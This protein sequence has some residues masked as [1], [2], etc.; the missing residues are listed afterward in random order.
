MLKDSLFDLFDFDLNER[1]WLLLSLAFW[2]D[3][4]CFFFLF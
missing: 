4:Q 1:Y 3:F 2:I